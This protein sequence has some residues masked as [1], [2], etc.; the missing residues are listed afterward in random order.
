MRALSIL[1][2]LLLT[3]VFPSNGQVDWPLD[4]TLPCLAPSPSARELQAYAAAYQ[5]YKTQNESTARKQATQVAIKVHH[6]LT[7]QGQG[8]VSAYLAQ[9]FTVLNAKFAPMGLSFFQFGTINYIRSD[10]FYDLAMSEDKALT[11][12]HNV[13]NAVNLYF[14]GN[15][16]GANGYAY[17][18]SLDSTKNTS[19]WNSLFISTNRTTPPAQIINEVI[20]H[21]M[22]HYFGLLHTHEHGTAGNLDP[23]TREYVTR[24]AAANCAYAG[25]QIC[26]TPADPYLL[27]IASDRQL[28][29]SICSSSFFT[30]LDPRRELYRPDVTNLM[31]YYRGCRTSFT[32]QQYDRMRWGLSLRN[33]VNPDPADRYYI[34]GQLRFLL[35]PTT[36]TYCAG[37]ELQVGLRQYGAPEEGNQFRLRLSG[38][39]GTNA[40]EVPATL[41]DNTRL[42]VA[43]PA[44]LPSGTY[45][46]QVVGSRPAV[47]SAATPVPITGIPQVTVDQVNGKLVLRASN[48]SS[49]QW[50]RDGVA[51]KDSTRQLLYPA[52]AG[53][54]TVQVSQ[55]GCTA[56]SEPFVIT[57]TDPANQASILVYPNPNRGSFWVEVPVHTSPEQ[58]AVFSLSGQPLF[59]ELLSTSDQHRSFIRMQ[60]PPGTYL[61]RITIGGQTSSTTFVIDR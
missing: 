58:T 17:P 12:T 49:H 8:D 27:L 43:L 57:A 20:P 40:V 36:A 18:P 53:A 56:A 9:V 47:V 48:A 15:A 22:G 29:Q 11:S 10:E 45:Q 54:Y 46:V 41:L 37:S 1:L 42:R 26:D 25:D 3:L 59:H 28:A 32:P 23:T 35:E 34:D 51:L 7:S 61:L 21:E 39:T 60:A 16:D 2:L 38:T 31:S 4:P 13:H 6:V 33:Q 14:V 52:G 44:N 55:A 5:Q 30:N 50:Y 19:H 24:G